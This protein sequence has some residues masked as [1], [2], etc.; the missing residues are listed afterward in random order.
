MPIV[1]KANYVECPSCRKW[2]HAP[3]TTEQALQQ[4]PVSA[5]PGP[6]HYHGNRV[7]ICQ[8]CY[9]RADGGAVV[10]QKIERHL[11]GAQEK[12]WVYRQACKCTRCASITSQITAA[13]KLDDARRL[14]EQAKP[15]D[16]PPVRAKLEMPTMDECIRAVVD[17]NDRDYHTESIA[18]VL[19]KFV[20]RRNAKL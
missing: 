12:E 15:L 11:Y 13:Q 17:F 10:L 9:E 18:W 16:V 7:A 2:I 20:E 3:I 8:E 19:R 14:A 1:N 4:F 6:V 5:H